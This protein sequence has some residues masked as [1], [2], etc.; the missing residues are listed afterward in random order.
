MGRHDGMEGEQR[1]VQVQ[2]DELEHHGEQQQHDEQGQHD[3]QGKHDEQV[4]HD[5]QEQHDELVQNGELVHDEQVLHDELV[6]NGEQYDVL[7]H[8]EDQDDEVGLVFH[9]H[10]T[11]VWGSTGSYEDQHSARTRKQPCYSPPGRN[12]SA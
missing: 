6:Q 8:D 7:G 9:I 10:P 1:D 11:L 5:G 4:Q 3:V 2:Y 12:A